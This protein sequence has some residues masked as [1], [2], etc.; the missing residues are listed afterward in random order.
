MFELGLTATVLRVRGQRGLVD[1]KGLSMHRGATV[2]LRRL[3]LALTFVLVAGALALPAAA[4]GSTI[5]DGPRAYRASISPSCVTGSGATTFTLT[6]RNTSTQQDLGSADVSLGFVPTNA[7][8]PTVVPPGRKSNP[9]T[10]TVVGDVLQLRGLAAPPGAV[11]TV[12]FTGTP[13]AGEYPIG[14]VAKQANNFSGP[15]GNDLQLY[16]DQPVVLVPED[17]A[18]EL[19]SV[20]CTG[21]GPCVA[22][23]NIGGFLISASG[24]VVDGTGTLAIGT[25]SSSDGCDDP[26]AGVTLN[27]I[28]ESIS[29]AAT[30]LAGKRIVF[31]IPE[32][33]RKATPNNGV[34]TY[35]ICAEPVGNPAPV[36]GTAEGPDGTVSFVDRYSGVTVTGTGGV[37]APRGWLPDCRSGANSVTAPCVHSRN[38]TDDGG[39]RI[40]VDFG[41]RYKMAS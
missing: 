12:T 20:S 14:I 3:A 31:T 8:T 1:D 2:P 17:G 21:D 15:P 41:S 5:V 13:A 33:I 25:F 39:V 27:T 32:E 10:P 37:G 19:V 26:P 34:S 29:V 38:G 11:V 7:T 18:C 28:P 6:L 36:G 30:G 9:T 35:Q 16:G 4:D 22:N 24:T 23:T 40:E